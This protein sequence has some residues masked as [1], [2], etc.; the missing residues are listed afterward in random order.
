MV[1]L[2]HEELS[3]ETAVKLHRNTLELIAG[4]ICGGGPTFAYRKGYQLTHFFKK[5]CDLPYEHDGTSRNWWTTDVLEQLNQGVATDQ[6]LPSDDLVIVFRA[7]LNRVIFG[8]AEL[9]GDA[10]NKLNSVLD[11]EGLAAYFDDAADDGVLQVRRVRGGTADTAAFA[12]ASRTWTTEERRRYELLAKYLGEASE[13]DFTTKA[14][15]PLLDRRGFQRIEV[16]GHEDKSQEFGKDLWMKFR[17]PTHHFIYFAVQ[18]KKGTVDAAAT[19]RSGRSNVAELLNQVQM[20]LGHEIFDPEINQAVLVDHVFLV[21]SGEI[22][23]AAKQWLGQ[24]LDNEKRRHIIF[25]DRAEIL[26]LYI[27]YNLPLPPGADP[28]EPVPSFDPFAD[29]PMPA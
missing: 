14:L 27:R 16:S 20:A 25:M 3:G 8:T 18:V 2:V 13:D 22:T 6:R 11:R 4:L 26:D 12:P 23:K 7:L 21:A 28:K 9:R 1:A 19:S 15:V 17:L 10:L 29:E 24:R 5:D